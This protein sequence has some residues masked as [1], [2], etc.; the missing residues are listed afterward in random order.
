[1]LLGHGKKFFQLRNKELL[2][3]LPGYEECL[4]AENLQE[5]IDHSYR[6]AGCESKEKFYEQYNPVN[7]VHKATKPVLSINS[8]DGE[9]I[10]C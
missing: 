1:M 7:F 5:W 10:L 3:H 4:A 8:E 2:Q 9:Y 6:M